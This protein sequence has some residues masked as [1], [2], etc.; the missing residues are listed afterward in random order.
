M[1]TSNNDREKNKK[2]V[3]ENLEQLDLGK[4]VGQVVEFPTQAFFK[5]QRVTVVPNTDSLSV[6]QFMDNPLV[7]VFASAKNPGGGFMNGSNAQEEFIFRKTNLYSLVAQSDFYE[8]HRAEV[9]TGSKGLLYSDHMIYVKNATVIRDKYDI[10]CSAWNCS[11]VFA[12][13]PN[14]KAIKENYLQP[15]TEQTFKDVFTRRIRKIF[16]IAART[17]HRN[18]VLGGWGCGVFG[19]DPKMVSET[20][21]EVINAS[22]S[23]AKFCEEIIFPFPDQ[24]DPNYQQFEHTFTLS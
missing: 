12:A 14:I 2:V 17:G 16:D 13:A 19:A 21:K 24:K 1:T 6:A 22:D 4:D 23:S 5:K 10:V 15:P 20:F 3:K 11:F 18:I 9:G 8:K 7:L